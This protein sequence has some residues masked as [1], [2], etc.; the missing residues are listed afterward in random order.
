MMCFLGNSLMASYAV[1]RAIQLRQLSDHVIHSWFP[2]WWVPD[3]IQLVF[4]AV[5]MTEH[6]THSGVTFV[7]QVWFF[8]FFPKSPY[9]AGQQKNFFKDLPAVK[10]A[11]FSS[12]NTYFL[13]KYWL[14]T[15]IQPFRLQRLL[16]DTRLGK[17]AGDKPFPY[18]FIRFLHLWKISS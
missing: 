12:L 16:S 7:H 5:V 18:S 10:A 15:P 9:P 1:R 4:M 3:R 8:D 14:L 13:L 17:V 2:R 11:V 6:W